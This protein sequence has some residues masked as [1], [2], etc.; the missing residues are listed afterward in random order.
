MREKK[1]A[2][3]F[4]LG[5]VDFSRMERGFRCAVLYQLAFDPD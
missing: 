4:R 3:H 2:L 5:G 1:H